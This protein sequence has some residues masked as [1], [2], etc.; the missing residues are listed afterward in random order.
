MPFAGCSHR[1]KQRRSYMGLLSGGLGLLLLYAA[2]L[3]A[4]ES[5]TIHGEQFVKAGEQVKLAIVI[6]K[7]PNFNGSGLSIDI[8]GPEDF[9]WR[10]G[11]GLM[12]GQTSYEMTFTLPEAAPGGKYS[13]EKVWFNSGAGNS[14]DLPFN[15][16]TFRVIPKKD[17]VYPTSA[18]VAISPNQLQLLRTEAVH[19]QAEIQD[20]KGQISE[21]TD[22]RKLASLL[23]QRL[24]DAIAKLDTTER[25]FRGLESSPK[26]QD[27]SSPFFG[28]IRTSYRE[29]ELEIKSELRESRGVF[30]QVADRKPGYPLIAR[31]ALHA[32]EQNELAYNLVADTQSLVFDLDTSSVPP[33]ATVSYRRRGDQFT[34]APNPT[35]STIKSLVYAIWLVRFE[36]PGYEI[37]EREHDPFREPN[38][39]ITVTLKKSK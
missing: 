30:L 25:E 33:G 9:L 14:L 38:H 36:E 15:K 6:D 11:V 10:Q 29:A 13:V 26:Q 23:H 8:R 31:A 16:Y 7:S 3:F 17:L 27:N 19:L 28:D 12:P 22:D 4:Q 2:A 24:N 39:S 5:A 21:Q 34:K 1:D 32:F 35:N 20:L 37:V 18:D